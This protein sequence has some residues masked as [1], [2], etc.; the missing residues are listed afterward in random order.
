MTVAMG[1]DDIGTD[2]IVANTQT[3]ATLES[4]LDVP[5]DSTDAAHSIPQDADISTHLTNK[6][7]LHTPGL[8]DTVSSP[9]S[10]TPTQRDVSQQSLN[11]NYDTLS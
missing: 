1:C 11:G 8:T 6:A 2:V 3:E 9:G 7:G 10:A 4:T 5:H